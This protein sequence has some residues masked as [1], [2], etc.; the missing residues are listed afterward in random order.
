M[1]VTDTDRTVDAVRKTITVQASP[2]RAFH[3]FTAEYDSWWPRSHH[4]G[5]S[6]MKRAIIEGRAGGRCYTEQED[7]TDCEWGSVLVW[8]PPHRIVI[9]W[10]IDGKWQFEPDLAR[11]SEVEVRFTAEP[12]GRTRV[13]LEHRHL[14]RHGLDAAAIRTAIDSPNGWGGLL[15][16]FADRLEGR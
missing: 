16:M 13:D 11:S 12:G 8:E 10:Q 2:E 14:D 4:I 1:T 5:K 6:P 3:V 9:A 15:Q 7:G